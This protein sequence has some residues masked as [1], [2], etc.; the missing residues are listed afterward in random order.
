MKIKAYWR[1]PAT[2]QE[3]DIPPDVK[4]ESDLEDFVS[5]NLEFPMVELDWWDEVERDA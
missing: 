3:L 2:V 5:D 4:T 1:V